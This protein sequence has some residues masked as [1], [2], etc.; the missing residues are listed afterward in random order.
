[1]NANGQIDIFNLKGVEIRA[2]VEPSRLCASVVEQIREFEPDWTL[3][4]SEDRSQG[5]LEA[6][7]RAHP[8]RVIYLAHT[9]QMFPFGPAGLYPGKRRAELIGRAAGIITIS[10]FVADYIK[11]WTGFESFV[12]HPPHYGPAPFPN[13]GSIENDYVLMMNACAVKGMPIFLALARAMP[14]VKFAALPGW[15][16]T[17]ADRIALAGLRNLSL[18]SN[19]KNL[20]DVFRRTRAVLM[21]SLW[22]EGF[23]MAAVDAMLRGIPVLASHHGGLIEAKLGTD[24]L[25]PVKPI[26]SFE[27]RLDDNLLPVPIVPTQDVGPWQN[28]LSRLVSDRD[29]YARQSAAARDATRFAVKM[30]WNDWWV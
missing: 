17:A 6:A 9:P 7:L 18:L 24:Y 22:V 28:A 14:N 26:E 3:V 4:S 1:V 19:C 29:L 11:Q 16:T 13:L 30:G 10:R 21:P 8:S 12:L 5:L 2:V 15:G 27:D 25:L 20:D 23:G